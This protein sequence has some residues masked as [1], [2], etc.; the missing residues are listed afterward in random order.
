MRTWLLSGVLVLASAS[1]VSPAAFGADKPKTA[2]PEEK[3]GDPAPDTKA[4]QDLLGKGRYED[5]IRQ[6]KLALARD[7]RYVPAMVVMAKAYYHLRKFELAGSIIDIAKS[8]DAN[9]AECNNLLGFLALEN[10][11]RI[12]ATAAFKKA[13]E[14]DGNF[15]PGWLNLCAQYLAAKNYD[16]AVDSGERAAKLMPNS[17]RAHLNLGSAYRGKQR[18]AEAEK[19]YKQA[20]VL[21]G[22]LADAWFNL[23]ILYLDAKEM[24]GV[25]DLVAKLNISISHF[26]RYKQLAGYKITKDDPADTY[27]N[28]C[29]TQID[30][31]QKR[32]ER[33]KKQQD[34]NKPKDAGGATAAPAAAP[35]SGG[36]PKK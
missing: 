7:E 22:S 10:N 26:N 1:A 12:S 15:G 3:K 9:N 13:T 6:S 24:P 27:L 28:D 23:G 11:D 8:I 20:S 30:R 14:S 25:P 2:L 32:L 18:Y 29:R 16:G 34:R 5:A 35:A 31:E 21:D 33:M 4:A 17:A 19:E 36:A